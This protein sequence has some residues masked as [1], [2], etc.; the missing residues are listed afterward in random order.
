MSIDLSLP[1]FA[2]DCQNWLIASEAVTSG[3]DGTL[4]E[5][6]DGVPVLAVLSTALIGSSDIE[7]AS[8]VFSLGLMDSDVE[9]ELLADATAADAPEVYIHE[10]AWAEGHARFVIPAADGYLAVIAEFCS[11]RDPSP[12]LVDRFSTLVSSFRWNV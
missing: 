10:T 6:I 11:D 5:D 2:L 8:A 4:S 1:T 7:S 12:E 3:A 9:L